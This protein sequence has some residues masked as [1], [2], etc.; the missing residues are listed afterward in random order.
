M[1][2]KTRALIWMTALTLSCLLSLGCGMT[3]GPKVETRYV[4]PLPGEPGRVMGKEKVTIQ[5]LDGSEAPVKQDIGGWVV[6]PW[7]HWSAVKRRVG[8]E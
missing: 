2:S 8:R 6:M 3:L 4:F 1:S 7:E 5:L